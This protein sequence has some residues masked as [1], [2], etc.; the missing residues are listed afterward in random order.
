MEPSFRELKIALTEKGE[1]MTVN[2]KA[3]KAFNFYFASLAGS[4]VFFNW[5]FI[6]SKNTDKK[7]NTRICFLNHSSILKIQQMFP[8]TRKFYVK[9]VSEA[10]V[11]KVVKNFASDKARSKEI[12]IKRLLFFKT[13]KM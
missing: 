4:L 13:C 11:G 9:F 2:S 6:S 7:Q 12:S 10:T 1:I 3:D 5:P 8:K